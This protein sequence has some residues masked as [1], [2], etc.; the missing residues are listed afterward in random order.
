MTVV[1]DVTE[2]H[3]S[4][5]SYRNKK[6]ITV[7]RSAFLQNWDGIY[8]ITEPHKESGEK[9]Y[10]K[11]KKTSLLKAS[12]PLTLVLLL[13]V[14]SFYGLWFMFNGTITATIFVQYILYIAGV[15][16]ASLLV[17]YEIDRNNPLLKKVCTGIFKGN[18]EVILTSSGAKLL[19]WLSW[20]EIGIFYFSG[21]LLSL[22]FVPGAISILAWF[23]VLAIPYIFFSLYYQWRV[24]KHWCVLCLCVQ[25]LLLI[26]GINMIVSEYIYQPFALLLPTLI[27]LFACF[28]LPALFWHTAKPY[29]VSLQRAS[30]TKREYLRFK[31]NEEIFYTLLS[32]R[33]TITD[34]VTTLGIDIGNPKAPHLL[35][36]VCN[37][38]C[39]P[40]ANAHP[41]IERLLTKVNNLQVKI[42]F[43][44][45]NDDGNIATKPVKHLLA[46]AEKQNEELTKKALDD[47]YLAEKKDYDSFAAKYPMNGE[48][49]KQGVKLAAMNSWCRKMEVFATPTFF[50]DGTEVPDAYNI[51]DLEYF[52]LE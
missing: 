1:T 3:I 8:L 37:P 30:D 35:I 14:F 20:S 49:L 13:T 22:L 39:E 26:G 21:S 7:E 42:I 12:V 33:K 48:L 43:N 2:S 51:E 47:W 11:V 10:I 36:K 19:N 5:Y 38:Y 4:Y 23:N 18:C 46:I 45:P 44:T 50:L 52:L 17:W 31:F 40:C 41:E 29:F 24:A 15:I 6:T 16:I 25:V 28:V 27:E 34:P 9:H 32:K